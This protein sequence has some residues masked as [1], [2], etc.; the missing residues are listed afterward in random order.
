ML[1]KVK[2]KYCQHRWIPRAEK[3]LACPACKRYGWDKVDEPKVE[4][5]V[6]TVDKEGN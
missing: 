6:E 2:C 5:V 1:K 3:P 4:Q